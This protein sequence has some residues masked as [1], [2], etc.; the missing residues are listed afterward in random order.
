MYHDQLILGK[1]YI[2]L[3]NFSVDDL[4]AYF[5]D[6]DSADRIVVMTNRLFSTFDSY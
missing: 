5:R 6:K 1:L 3:G 2:F 4:I